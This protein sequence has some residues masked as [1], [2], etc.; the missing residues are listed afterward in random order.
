MK[1]KKERVNWSEQ[2]KLDR[3]IFCKEKYSYNGNQGE[4]VLYFSCMKIKL[5]NTQQY[6][7]ENSMI[8]NLKLEKSRTTTLL[9][10]YGNGVIRF[11]L[12]QVNFLIPL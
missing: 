9:A 4:E 5:W 8:K 6:I 7:I 10:W 2:L 1:Q 3:N 11:I 12:L